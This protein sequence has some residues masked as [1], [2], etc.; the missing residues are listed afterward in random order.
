MNGRATNVTK[1]IIDDESSVEGSD[2]L[3]FICFL[4]VANHSHYLVTVH[5]RNYDLS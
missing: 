5:T 1:K 3:F 4:S 2:R